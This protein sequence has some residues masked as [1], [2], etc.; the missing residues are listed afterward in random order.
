MDEIL[1]PGYDFPIGN[2]VDIHCHMLPGID[3]GA[4]DIKTSWSMID[5]SVSQGVKCICFTPHFYADSDKPKNFLERRNKAFLTVK[6]SVPTRYPVMS[7]GA[8]IHYYEG[9][10]SMEELRY[11]RILGT[12]LLLIEMPFSKWTDRMISDIEEINSRSEYIVVLAHI[13]RYLKFAAPEVISRLHAH[14]VI[15]QSNAGFFIERQ[16]RR[17]ALKMFE[18][19]EIDVLSSDSHNMN[20]RPP[21]LKKAFDII[22]DRFGAG[23]SELLIQNGS[24]LVKNIMPDSY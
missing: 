17:T 15:I 14:G 8:E 12:E 16:T 11:M 24:E 5:E 3:D 1:R 21:N 22:D 13:E 20:S 4:K 19:R 7:C 23:A 2:L 18:N 10:T 9:L 6:K